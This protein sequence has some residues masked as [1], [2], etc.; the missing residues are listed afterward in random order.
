MA[1][2]A[3]SSVACGG[4]GQ[5]TNDDVLADAQDRSTQSAAGVVVFQSLG[6]AEFQTS[7]D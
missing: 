1:L 2:L 4:N 6:V 5:G 3:F 7:L